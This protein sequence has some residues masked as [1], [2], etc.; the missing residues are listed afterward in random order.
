M[1]NWE[2]AH[3]SAYRREMKIRWDGTMFEIHHINGDHED[4][5][6]D[7][8]ILLPGYLHR[9]LHSVLRRSRFNWD[10]TIKSYVLSAYNQGN[11]GEYLATLDWFF[12]YSQIVRELAFWGEMK[13]Q[14]YRS[15]ITGKLYEIEGIF[16]YGR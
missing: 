3:K 1:A 15:P 5:A 4:N 10:E 13:A 14:K 7:N 6:I 11:N 12:L 16:E 9:R 8:L 2:A